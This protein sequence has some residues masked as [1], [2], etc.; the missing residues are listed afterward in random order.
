MEGITI[1]IKHLLRLRNSLT[2]YG[3]KV[4]V[5]VDDYENWSKEN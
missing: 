2:F 5:I 3:G 4:K 1:F